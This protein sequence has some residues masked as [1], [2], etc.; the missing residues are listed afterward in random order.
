MDW[1]DGTR[2]LLSL[3]PDMQVPVE[4]KVNFPTWTI[5]TPAY[6]DGELPLNAADSVVGQ[7]IRMFDRQLYKERLHVVSGTRRVGIGGR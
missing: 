2:P 1:E 3:D 4:S 7:I 5:V 6:R